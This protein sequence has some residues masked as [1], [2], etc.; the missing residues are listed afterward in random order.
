MKKIN[1]KLVLAAVALLAEMLP[2]AECEAQESIETV[3]R[4]SRE[5]CQSIQGGH[6]VMERKMQHMDDKDTDYYRNT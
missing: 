2:V 3:I 4:K 5:K 6:Y 1:L